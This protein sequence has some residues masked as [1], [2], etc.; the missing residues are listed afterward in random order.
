MLEVRPLAEIAGER[1]AQAAEVDLPQVRPGADP[2]RERSQVALGEDP[3]VVEAAEV[4][5]RRRQRTADAASGEDNVLQVVEVSEGGRQRAGEPR[6]LEADQMGQ[7]GHRGRQG[8]VDRVAAQVE[9]L[10][11]GAGAIAG[12]PVPGALGATGSQPVVTVLPAR[13]AER[14]VERDQ[15][16]PLARRHRRPR[17]PRHELH[18]HQAGDHQ[19]ESRESTGH[20]TQLPSHPAAPS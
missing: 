9:H 7:P 11:G 15:S 1:T 6:N 5:Q 20:T 4:R 13:A 16:G 18:H 10:D 8:A 3:Q 2:V 19:A 14:V 12:H 17:R